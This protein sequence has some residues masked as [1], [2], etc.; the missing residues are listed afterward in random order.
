[1][2]NKSFVV[3]YIIKM[4]E[5][6][7]P[8]AEKVRRATDRMRA[9]LDQSSESIKRFKG[10][11]KRASIVTVAATAPI[12]LLA[13]SMV[14]AASDAEETRAKFN[15][16]FK[17]IATSA[18]RTADNLADNFGLAGSKA[19]ELLGDTGDLLTGF[20][21][22][23]AG[24][25]DLSN[26][27]NE[28]AVDLASFTNFSGGAEGASKAITSALLGEREAL[29]SLGVAISEKQVKAK[30]ALMAANGQKFA[31]L[32]QAKAHA[33]LAL[34][35]EQSKNAIG[36]YK[37]T[38]QELANQQ[39]LTSS[40]ITDLKESF[41]KI[42]LP[43]ALQLT[44]AIRF[45]VEWFTALSPTTKKIILVVAGLVAVLGPL[46]LVIGAIGLALPFLTAGF[47]FFGAVSLS[48]LLPVLG[49]AAALVVA[50]YLIMDIWGK[51][52]VLFSGFASGINLTFGPTL[53]ELADKFI[54]TAKIISSWFGSDSQVAQDL[55]GLAT[56]G[57]F[58]GEAVGNALDFIVQLI[59]I[60][61][62]HLGQL[63]AA[64]V[65]MDFSHFNIDRL[66]EFISP[67]ENPPA[68]INGSSKTDVNVNVGLDKGLQ[69]T[70]PTK[71][72]TTTGRRQDVGQLAG[73]TP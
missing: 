4:R 41:G 26:R 11:M 21:F 7:A 19:R 40:R 14:K 23:Q 51:V 3:Q 32:Q 27:V 28:L 58:I 73:V 9:S 50:A 24:A 57:K 37:R 39:R 46:L 71:T 56:I 5:T 12:L 49:I 55:A 69:Q 6:F 60:A 70:G 59:M 52:A 64:I 30:I 2:A 29:K 34:A 15:T 67:T 8:A 20:G 66:K 17:D 1:M 31:S 36:D 72:K 43:A 25:L 65:T 38:S 18:N 61:G 33:T 10:L 44:K 45:L 35:V 62:D 47:A 13:R 68:N 53:R 42:L 48:A 63:I 54:E 16:V 22:T